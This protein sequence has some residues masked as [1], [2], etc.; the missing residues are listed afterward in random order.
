MLS[1]DQVRQFGEDGY[2]LGEQVLQPDEV[3]TL[4][5]ETERTIR[6]RDNAAVRQPVSCRNLSANAAEPIW[7]I[8]NIWQSSDAFERL[9]RHPAIA[10]NV[11]ALLKAEEL[12]LWHDQIQYKPAGAGGVNMWHQDWPYWGV[13]SAPEQVTAWIALDDADEENGCMSMV[14]GSHRWG[15]NI[16]FLHTLGQDFSAMPREFEGRKLEVR[17]CPV[18]AGHVHYHH[19]LTW[20]GSD[21]NRS[22]RK[23]R[24]IA[25]H[26][27]SEKTRFV[28]SG[29]HI[30]KRS[31]EVGDGEKI[32]GAAFPLLWSLTGATK[33]AQ[34]SAT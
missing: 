15:N 10:A 26:L 14:P 18:K 9:V 21:R 23:R 17:L 31:V 7:Q 13:L 24:A 25:L 8:V 33:A 3:A 1:K 30:M 16:E 34:L 19:G 22:N 5:V 12:R 4:C 27:M 11:A 32:A 2:I 29:M 6:D 28:A 20:H